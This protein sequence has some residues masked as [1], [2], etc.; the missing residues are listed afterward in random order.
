MATSI[1]SGDEK[2]VVQDP[3]V[4]RDEYRDPPGEA[5]ATGADVP[6]PRS[7][8]EVTESQ[9]S[10]KQG[11]SARFG[12]VVGSVASLLVAAL[13][14]GS[15]YYFGA[16]D[17]SPAPT[18][19]SSAAQPAGASAPVNQSAPLTG[20]PGFL[21][22]IHSMNGTSAYPDSYW[23]GLSRDVC[24]ATGTPGITRQSLIDAAASTGRFTATG[25]AT[26][27]DSANTHICPSR[28]YSSAPDY[29]VL[30]QAEGS[31]SPVPPSTPASSFSDGT[32]EVGNEA[33]QIRPGTYRTSG[34]SSRGTCYFARLTSITGDDII[35]NDLSSG[36]MILS[37]QSSDG[38][39][40]LRGGCTWTRR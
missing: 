35:D 7:S 21:S 2:S 17:A 30:Q 12:F 5:D 16:P 25:A 19:S 39:V 10:S 40:R 15:F 37:V 20:E 32:Y 1:E 18:A 14:V 29:R 38:A 9:T 22:A 36:P 34:G 13:A 33:G 27:V 3:E 24:N 23:L 26:L 28:R 4:S 6:A 8:P 11:H 31:T